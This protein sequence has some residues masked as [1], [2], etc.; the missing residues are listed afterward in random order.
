MSPRRTV[1]EL[2]EDA[3]GRI[4]RLEPAAAWAAMNPDAGMEL[5]RR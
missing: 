3:R 1:D 2:L 4:E 5:V